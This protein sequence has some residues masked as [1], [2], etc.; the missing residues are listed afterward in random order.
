MT[1]GMLPPTTGYWPSSPEV[2]ITT[3]PRC[4]LGSD[5]SVPTA[6][7]TACPSI[8]TRPATLGR[9]WAPPASGSLLSPQA[10]GRGPVPSPIIGTVGLAGRGEDGRGEE[11]R[12]EES[13]GE[14]GQD[15]DGRGEDGWG[16][17]GRGEDGGG[18]H[19]EWAPEL[20]AWMC[21]SKSPTFWFTWTLCSSRCRRRAAGEPGGLSPPR[22][23]R[24]P[25]GLTSC[26]GGS[27]GGGKRNAELRRGERGDTVVGLKGGSGQQLPAVSGL[28]GS[29]CLEGGGVLLPLLFTSLL[30]FIITKL[31]SA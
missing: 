23:P 24:R 25:P 15:E 16:E 31:L 29:A 20:C 18:L 4:G 12:G 17:E 14:D 2:A 10:C 11:G 30:L 8:T 9:S 28:L 5:G 26:G 27:S 1:A 22:L 7:P 6:C 3:S 21:A 19:G 13:R